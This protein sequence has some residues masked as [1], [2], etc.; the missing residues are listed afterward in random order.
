MCLMLK[1]HFTIMFFCNN[2]I[3]NTPKY[4]HYKC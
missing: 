3:R 1:A 4:Q 2:K